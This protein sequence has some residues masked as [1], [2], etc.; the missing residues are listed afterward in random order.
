MR[1]AVLDDVQEDREL[2]EGYLARFQREK[3]I[4]MEVYAFS[5]GLDFVEDY[6]GNWDI[7]LLD[8]EMP[9]LDGMEAAQAIR[10]KDETVGIIFITNMAQY[11]IRGYEV[12][13]IDFMVKPVGYFN[14]A[15]KMVKALRYVQRHGEKQMLLHNEDGIVRVVA[16]DIRYIVKEK[17]YVRYHTRQGVFTER[18]SLQSVQE[19]LA[20][21]PFSECSSGC[22]INLKYVDRIGADHVMLHEVRLPLSRRMKKRFTQDY[23][24]FVGGVL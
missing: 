6:D 1:V 24:D 11:A 22:L 18:A 12:D 23:I 10:E 3:G 21:C 13:A 14:L 9:G 7:R 2:L 16:S 4:P 8:I 20:G 5:S 19:K 15:Q 17:N